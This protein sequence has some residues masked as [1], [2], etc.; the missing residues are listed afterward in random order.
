MPLPQSDKAA[1]KRFNRKKSENIAKWIICAAAVLISLASFAIFLKTVEWRKTAI[2]DARV[3]DASRTLHSARS[4]IDA[5]FDLINDLLNRA[6]F[7][8]DRRDP[9]LITHSE[10]LEIKRLLG[11]ATPRK[12]LSLS[13]FDGSGKN[14]TSNDQMIDIR[15]RDHFKA[16]LAPHSEV[17]KLQYDVTRRLAISAPFLSRSRKF[18]VIAASKAIIGAGGAF[19]GVV[20]ITIP[21]SDLLEIFNL[22]R[23][24][25]HDAIFLMR[26][27]RVGIA[28]EPSHQSF[29]GKHLPNALVFQNYPRLPEGRF[30]GPAATDGIQRLGVHLSLAPLPLVLGFSFSVGDLLSEYSAPTAYETAIFAAL[31]FAIIA[32]AAFAFFAH[33][34][35][36]TFGAAAVEGMSRAQQAQLALQSALS[37]Q[38]ELRADA[39]AANRA[40]SAFLAN[41]SHELRTPLNAIL[42]FAG[43]MKMKVTDPVCQ[44]YA[45]YIEEGGNQLTDRISEILDISALEAGTVSVNLEPLALADVINAAMISLEGLADAHGVTLHPPEPPS[46][47]WVNADASKL[48]RV[49]ENLVSNGVKYN[50]P[51]GRVDITVVKMPAGY[52]RVSFADNG[53]GIPLERQGDLFKRFIRLIDDLG[54]IPGTG[55]G[56]AISRDLVALMNGHMGFKSEAGAGSEFWVDLV[57]ADVHSE[58]ETAPAAPQANAA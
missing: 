49:F 33:S 43:L 56:L 9:L 18:E 39:E 4:Y 1:A 13:I 58:V 47:L 6:L 37:R 28:R 46:Q 21:T 32:F 24:G 15:E 36:V 22:L 48:V 44:K 35:A 57:E 19:Q 7:L 10:L 38:E 29:S 34:K 52:V 20:A 2:I 8:V 12:N 30:E 11:S 55:L 26:N 16:H 3:Q 27:D 54:A 45:D 5:E 23:R 31:I 50:Q 17:T 25:E 14:L 51:G 41:M 42:G 53:T 40:K